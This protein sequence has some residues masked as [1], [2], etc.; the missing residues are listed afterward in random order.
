MESNQ[1]FSSLMSPVTHMRLCDRCMTVAVSAC[2]TFQSV[3]V[4]IGNVNTSQTHPIHMTYYHVYGACS[5]ATFKGMF[6]TVWDC[7]RMR[8]THAHNACA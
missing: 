6:G 7:E 3:H 2:V 1:Y 5:L 4:A 8:I